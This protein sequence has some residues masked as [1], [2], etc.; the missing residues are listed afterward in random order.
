MIQF[1]IDSWYPLSKAN[2]SLNYRYYISQASSQKPR[3]ELFGLDTSTQSFKEAVRAKQSNSAFTRTTALASTTI[4]GGGSNSNTPVPAASLF[5]TS[6]RGLGCNSASQSG[7][8]GKTSGYESLASQT[9][10][11]GGGIFG[12]KPAAVSTSGGLFGSS[13][14]V[15]PTTSAASGGVFGSFGS[16]DQRAT[17]GLFGS[18][19]NENTATIK[20]GCEEQPR[21]AN[22]FG[23]KGFGLWG[24]AAPAANSLVIEEGTWAES[25]MTATYDLPGNKTLAPS[26]NTMKQKITNVCYFFLLCM[27]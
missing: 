7:A 22:P 26:N 19:S 4:A 11:T 10:S 3:Y 21:P 14:S 6:N 5:G 13:S 17:T 15:A 16:V 1:L 9:A 12:A 20:E 24:G 25:G 27:Y 2:T 23:Q 18:S 8:F